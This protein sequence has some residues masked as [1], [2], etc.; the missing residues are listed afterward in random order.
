M[1]VSFNHHF[2]TYYFNT[3]YL[4]LSWYKLWVCFKVY[5]EFQISLRISAQWRCWWCWIGGGVPWCFCFWHGRCTRW[6]KAW[7]LLWLTSNALLWRSFSQ[8]SAIWSHLFGLLFWRLCVGM[9]PGNGMT[10]HTRQMPLSGAPI[11]HA[12]GRAGLS[13]NDRVFWP[14]PETIFQWNVL[15]SRIMRF[16]MICPTLFGRCLLTSPDLKP[17]WLWW[18][19]LEAQTALR[20]LPASSSV[21]ILRA[22]TWTFVKTPL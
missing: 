4:D 22:D 13:P 6:V 16:A 14:K 5:T 18:V 10:R 15:K 17:V 7:T 3:T 11:V 21:Q 1:Q 12:F 9:S 19:Q 8:S 2:V 20:G